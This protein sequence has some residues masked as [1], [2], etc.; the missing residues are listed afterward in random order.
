MDQ[1]ERQPLQRQI[2]DLNPRIE[3]SPQ[4]LIGDLR[5]HHHPP[6]QVQ[7]PCEKAGMAELP[8]FGPEREETEE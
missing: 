3:L 6:T 4:I 8:Q 5:R 2:H 7:K 1:T